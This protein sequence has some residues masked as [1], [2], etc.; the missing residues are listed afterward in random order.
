[1]GKITIYGRAGSSN[2]KAVLEKYG[3][4]AT[5][6]DVSEDVAKLQ[7][8]LKHS[9]G[10]K[11]VPVDCELVRTARSIGISFGDDVSH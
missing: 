5:Y 6:V 10:V 9:G 1:M 8:M 7:E 11:R 4:K 2:T 3:D